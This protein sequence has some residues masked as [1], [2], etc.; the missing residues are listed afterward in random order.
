MKKFFTN[1]WKKIT[2]IGCR[3][4]KTIYIEVRDGDC[5][6]LD[7]GYFEINSWNEV[8]PIGAQFAQDVISAL[9]A[10]EKYDEVYWNYKEV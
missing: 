5:Q 8:I 10:D 6:L 1:L 3:W 7:F 2:N 9:P 4:P